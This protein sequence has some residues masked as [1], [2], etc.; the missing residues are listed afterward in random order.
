SGLQAGCQRADDLS[1]RRATWEGVF[2]GE[3]SPQTARQHVGPPLAE[4][5]PAPPRVQQ[6]T[7]HVLCRGRVG[8][9]SKWVC[10]SALGH[11]LAC[12]GQRGCYALCPGALA[13]LV[14]DRLTGVC[15]SC[16]L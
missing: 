2:P 14:N 11:R 10:E 12:S 15:G 7:E 8:T 3:A 5:R 4:E 13:D 9:S 16:L 6:L 1:R